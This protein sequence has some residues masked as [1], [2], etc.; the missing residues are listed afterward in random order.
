MLL[1][2]KK[3]FL[4][5][6]ESQKRWGSGWLSSCFTSSLPRGGTIL[7]L[8]FTP[9]FIIKI[10]SPLT[11][12][13]PQRRE[14][15]CWTICTWLKL[16][17]HADVCWAYRWKT[18]TRPVADFV[19]FHWTLCSSAGDTSHSCESVW[20]FVWVCWC[21]VYSVRGSGSVVCIFS[22]KS[23]FLSDLMCVC[24]TVLRGVWV[25]AEKTA[26]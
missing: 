23:M 15:V 11:L 5:P 9:S 19:E 25:D 1:R 8:I 22:P 17:L 2:W 12:L 7:L 13:Q 3:L 20:V 10:V 24:T 4:F 14:S 21:V 18:E 26:V 16:C 6:L